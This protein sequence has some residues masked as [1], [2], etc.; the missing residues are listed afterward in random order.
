M[1]LIT[2]KY[3]RKDLYLDKGSGNLRQSNGIRKECTMKVSIGI[4]HY[5]A[6]H[7]CCV[8][9]LLDRADAMMY[10]HKRQRG[11]EKETIPLIEDKAS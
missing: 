6:E 5:D 1:I 8:E 9:A 7:P 2:E 11:L 10:T 4:V 3:K